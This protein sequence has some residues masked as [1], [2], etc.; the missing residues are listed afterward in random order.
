MAIGP[1]FQL[2]DGQ[3]F[4]DQLRER[5]AQNEHIVRHALES[6]S[7]PVSI[8]DRAERTDLS[9]ALNE[10]FEDLDRAADEIHA[11]ND[12]LFEAHIELEDVAAVFRAVFELAPFPY[13][14]TDSNTR[15]LLANHAACSLF[16]R[17]LNGLAG[18]PLLCFVP[19]DQRNAFRSATIRSNTDNA[20]TT[21]S[22]VFSPKGAD[23]PIP[24]RIRIRASS[25]LGAL[26]NRALYWSI[27]EET[28]EDLF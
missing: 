15:I 24:C 11:Q 23:A 16:R 10:T 22:T 20:I 13:V 17:S 28:D 1:G 21:W 26:A 25:R 27:T 6:A 4:A 9:R 12:A 7:L 2:S 8:E 18:K 3:V 19:L 5:R 14:V